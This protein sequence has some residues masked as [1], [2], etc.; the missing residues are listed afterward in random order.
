MCFYYVVVTI[1]G[2]IIPYVCEGICQYELI[3]SF[4]LNKR[5]RKNDIFVM[6]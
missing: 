5:R 4:N 3:K 6:K 1:S 2:F